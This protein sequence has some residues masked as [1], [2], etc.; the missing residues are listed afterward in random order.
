MRTTWALYQSRGSK[1]HLIRHSQ[2]AGGGGRDDEKKN[3]EIAEAR[4]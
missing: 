3:D 1:E 4:V 2:G